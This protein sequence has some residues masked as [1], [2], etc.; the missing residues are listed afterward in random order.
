[1][2]LTG[3][4]REIQALAQ[5]S[6]PGI[7]NVFDVQQEEDLFFMTMELLKGQTQ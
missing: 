5:I 3:I 1:M 6:H 7:V 2:A 4:R